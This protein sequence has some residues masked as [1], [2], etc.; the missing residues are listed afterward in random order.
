MAQKSQLPLGIAMNYAAI[1]NAALD[2]G[3]VPLADLVMDMA[4][5]AALEKKGSLNKPSSS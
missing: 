5:E 1:V 3:T 2:R 4:L